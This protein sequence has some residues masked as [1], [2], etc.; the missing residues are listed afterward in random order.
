MRNWI[1]AAFFAA[2]SSVAS[3]S[4]SPFSLPWMNTAHSTTGVRPNYV[5]A[6]RPNGIF[7]IEAYF[8]GCP[9]CNMNAQNVNDLATAFSDED[10]V[11]V[12]DVGTDRNDADYATWIARHNV[13]HP[14]LKDSSRT[15]IRQLGTTAFPSTYVIDCH[16]QIAFQGVGSWDQSEENQ[17]YAAVRNLLAQDCTP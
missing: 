8:L 14:V 7:V 4:V 11:Q 16:G 10:R 5:S 9:Y 13:N 1:L 12:L 6:D 2:A 15:L 17:I 3:A